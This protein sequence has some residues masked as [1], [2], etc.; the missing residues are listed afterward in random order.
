[1]TR[2]IRF[3]AWVHSEG[4]MQPVH[5]IDFE[6][7]TIQYYGINDQPID[8]VVLEQYTGLKDKNGVE[9]YEGDVVKDEDGVASE[10]EWQESMFTIS[11]H[12]GR[13]W[14]TLGEVEVIGNIHENPEL[15]T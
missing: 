7:Q 14:H 5:S 9:I 1:M 11:R 3:R 13:P 2:E 15:L 4:L 10:V 12:G 8:G 6:D